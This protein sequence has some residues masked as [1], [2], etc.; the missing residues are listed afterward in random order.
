MLVYSAIDGWYKVEIIIVHVLITEINDKVAIFLQLF[1]MKA[2]TDQLLK[3]YLEYKIFVC[4]L[5]DLAIVMFEFR[6]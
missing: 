2:G 6:V 4:V 3:E 5:T 1:S